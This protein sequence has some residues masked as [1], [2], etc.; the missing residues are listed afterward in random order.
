MCNGSN[1]CAISGTGAHGHG[2]AG[3][4]LV[5]GHL[6]GHLRKQRGP[7]RPRR[8][9]HQHDGRVGLLLYPA[10]EPPR[11]SEQALEQAVPRTLPRRQPITTPRV[12]RVSCRRAVARVIAI[13]L[14]SRTRARAYDLTRPHRR[15]TTSQVLFGNPEYASPDLSPDGTKLAF[16]KPS[17]KGVLNV[18]LRDLAA[19]EKSDRQVTADEYRGIRGFSWAEDN[20]HLLYMQD[21]GGDENFHLWKIETSEGAAAVDLTPFKGAK[22]QNLIT[23][24]R[25]P[26]RWTAIK[27]HLTISPLFPDYCLPTSPPARQ[28]ASS[29]SLKLT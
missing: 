3:V 23:N 10:N 5:G 29:P 1:A 13:A 4:R 28:S 16:L 2:T 17:S 26:V 11:L 19:G 22:A 6:V 15:P 20:K 25:F 27:H 24:K 12:R 18:W 9:L 8:P 7:P 14:P 21:D